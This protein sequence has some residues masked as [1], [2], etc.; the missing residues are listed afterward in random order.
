MVACGWWCDDDG[1]DRTT[2][3]RYLMIGGGVLAI[4]VVIAA[5][6]SLRGPAS[7]DSGTPESV[8]QEYV[9]AVF[10]G[11]SSVAHSQ[12]ADDLARGC[13]ERELRTSWV[14]DEAR[15]V[16]VGTTTA[17]DDTRVHIQII[18]PDGGL[19]MPISDYARDVTFVLT[20][21]EDGWRISEPPWPIEY[22]NGGITP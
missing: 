10:D 5:V 8:V 7:F 20:E 11:D 14:P 15:V 19:G 1:M 16:L 2:P 12:L 22:C 4:L 21:Q 18:E 9:N 13:S 6:L 17:G 3:N